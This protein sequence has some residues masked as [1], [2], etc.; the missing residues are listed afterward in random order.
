VL[1]RMHCKRETRRMRLSIAAG[2]LT[3]MMIGGGCQGP[4]SGPARACIEKAAW[5]RYGEVAQQKREI[6]APDAQNRATRFVS[7]A[8]RIDYLEA[9]CRGLNAYVRALE[10]YI[11]SRE[12]SDGAN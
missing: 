10:S 12:R 7:A 8:D 9:V 1:Y 4:S 3:W 2:A 11:E 5:A 6:F